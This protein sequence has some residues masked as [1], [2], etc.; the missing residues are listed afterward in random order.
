MS[1]HIG[2]DHERGYRFRIVGIDATN[3]TVSIQY[4]ATAWDTSNRLTE[5]LLCTEFLERL[6]AGRFEIRP[7]A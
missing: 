7:A 6:A 1:K 3:Q 4:E 5:S 2:Q